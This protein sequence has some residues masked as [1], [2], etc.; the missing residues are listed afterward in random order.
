MDT[1]IESLSHEVV[2][3]S[4]KLTEL[5]ENLRLKFKR[6]KIFYKKSFQSMKLRTIQSISQIKET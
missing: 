2:E 1:Q 4:T 3:S 6:D 5:Q